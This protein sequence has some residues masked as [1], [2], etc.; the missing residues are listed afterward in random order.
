MTALFRVGAVGS[1]NALARPCSL[2]KAVET[3]HR[4]LDQTKGPVTLRL[5][6][7]ALRADGTLYARRLDSTPEAHVEFLPNIHRTSATASPP[8]WAEKATA[9]L[10]DLRPIVQATA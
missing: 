5:A 6:G 1:V 4:L 9:L 10:A 7:D 8:E 3:A 2:G